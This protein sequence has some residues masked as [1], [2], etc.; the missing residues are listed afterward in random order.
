MMNFRKWVSCQ[1]VSNKLLSAR[2]FRFCDED[3]RNEERGSQEDTESMGGTASISNSQLNSTQITEFPATPHL[4]TAECSYPGQVNERKD[5]PLAKVEELQ[6]KFLRIVHRIGL[7]PENLVVSQVL[8]RLQLASLIRAGDSDVKRTVL[9]VNKARGIASELEAVGRSVLDFSLKILVLG[10]TGVGKSS[11]INSIFEQPMSATNAFHPGTDRIQEIVGFIKGIKVTVIDTPGL[12]PSRSNLRQ[13]RK[14][15]LSIKRFIR[16]S[17]PDVVLYFERLDVINRGYSDYPLLKLIT[18]IFGSSIW[19]NTI[20]V[21]THSSSYPPE[22]SDGYPVAYDAFVHQCTTIVQHYVR[23][24]ISNAQFEAPVILVENHPRCRTNA[25]G[26]KVLPNG[27][28]W[29][30]QFLLLCTATKVLADANLLLKFQD[31]FQ[32]T[33]N[34]NRVPSLPH[35]LSTIL[36]PRFVGSGNGFDN[37]VDELVDNDEDDYDQL[38][39][40]RILTR[41]QFQKLSKAQKNAYLDELDYRET[42]YLKKQWKEE[43]RKRREILLHQNDRST[44]ND[45]YEDNT[46]QEVA[47]VSDMAIPLSFDADYPAYRFRSVLGNDQWLVRPVLDPQGW[48]HDVGFDGISLEGSQDVRRNIQASLVGQ[49]RKDKEDLSIQSECTASYT[50]PKHCS[51]LA[52]VGVQTTAKDLVL[53][54]HGDAKFVNLKHNTTGG[55]LSVTKYG[56]K[57]VVGGKLEDS[58]SIGRRCK[59]TLNTGQIR[60]CG[61][62]A[63]GGSIEA[64]LRG[65]DY[66]VRDDKVTLAT[67][68]LSL[69]KEV[70]LGGSIQTDFRAGRSI[71]MSINANLNSRGLGQISVKTST[72]E[73]VEIALVAIFSLV[74]SLLQRKRRSNFIDEVDSLDH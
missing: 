29:L 47:Q 11:T 65:K 21:M 2:P 63:S 7:T 8:Y 28:V 38:P 44:S 16:K 13:N 43:L 19:F 37:D 3:I 51:L 15:L 50:D 74:R 61:Q 14:L 36:R 4:V 58:L 34:S 22:G 41:S 53:T 39:P 12:S 32:L 71:K 45:D 64:T 42:L 31:S 56:S 52:E 25:K 6:I 62:V 1:L 9:K 30:S 46:P 24:T 73:H 70:V 26:E 66:P 57:Y 40:I 69:D 55:G 68:I 20:L 59:L 17:P 27:Q 5:D 67:T 72:S 33:P 54:I 60:G 23:Q 18:D 35:L 48:D 49:M 10:K